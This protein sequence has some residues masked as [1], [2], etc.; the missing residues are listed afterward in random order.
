MKVVIR[1]SGC[2]ELQALPL[3]LRHSPGVG[4][5]QRTYIISEEAAE[6]LRKA[7]IPFTELGNAA[8]LPD[9]EG[10]LSGERV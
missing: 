2:A 1:V 6:T 8:N 10:A 4:L 9:L 7:G 5:P 3:L